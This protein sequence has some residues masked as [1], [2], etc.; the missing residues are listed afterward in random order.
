MLNIFGVDIN[1]SSHSHNEG[2]LNMAEEKQKTIKKAVRFSG[3]ALHT[4]ARA[5][6]TIKP[7]GETSG[8]MFRR[9]DLSGAPEV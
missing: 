6:M 3:I 9:V 7:A 5:T 2:I 1:E 8:I 4:G